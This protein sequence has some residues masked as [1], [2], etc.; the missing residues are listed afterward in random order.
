MSIDLY[1]PIEGLNPSHVYLLT[2]DVRDFVHGNGEYRTTPREQPA[3][4]QRGAYQPYVSGRDLE[5]FP[6][7]SAVFQ[8]RWERLTSP[9][10]G[11]ILRRAYEEQS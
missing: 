5:R 4:P 6:T 10:Q 3:D 1:S 9:Q 8:A 2:R 7:T 11:E